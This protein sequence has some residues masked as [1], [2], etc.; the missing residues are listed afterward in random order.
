MLFR[1]R[2]QKGELLADIAE[3]RQAGCVAITDD[4]HP[5]ATALLLRRALAKLVA[6]SATVGPGGYNPRAVVAAPSMISR[7]RV[8]AAAAAVVRRLV[9]S[10]P[11]SARNTDFM[12]SQ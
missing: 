6:M 1:S 9:H 7:P 11:T 10:R 8:L 12:T 2:G 5:T 4:G 3:L